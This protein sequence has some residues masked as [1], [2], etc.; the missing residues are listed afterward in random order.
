MMVFL[1]LFQVS[2]TLLPVLHVGALT[3]SGSMYVNCS[4]YSATNTIDDT[5]DFLPGV[6]EE[7]SSWPIVTE[8]GATVQANWRSDQYEYLNGTDVCSGQKH[9]LYRAGQ[10]DLTISATEDIGFFKDWVMCHA[11]NYLN[12]NCRSDEGFNYHLFNDTVITCLAGELC[13]PATINSLPFDFDCGD[14]GL[15]A[16]E[17]SE[18]D[19]LTHNFTYSYDITGP[20]LTPT[21]TQ[22]AGTT[23]KPVEATTLPWTNT[24][25]VSFECFDNPQEPR[26]AGEA[27]W[28]SCP[29]RDF[30]ANITWWDNSSP[31][32]STQEYYNWVMAGYVDMTPLSQFVV[33]QGTDFEDYMST[34]MGNFQVMD[35]GEYDPWLSLLFKLNLLTNA[36]L[37]APFQIQRTNDNADAWDAWWNALHDLP[38]SGELKAFC[39]S[40]AQDPSFT[41]WT[42]GFPGWQYC[43][44]DPVYGQW[45]GP[46]IN[47]LMEQ[48]GEI[49]VTNLWTLST[50]RQTAEGSV[51]PNV[52]ANTSTRCVPET[53]GYSKTV[54][55]STTTSTQQQYSSSLTLSS[56]IQVSEKADVSIGV[57]SGEEQTTIKAGVS[58][59]ASASI[60]SGTSATTTTSTTVNYDATPSVPPGC[61]LNTTVFV[62]QTTAEMDIT[63]DVSYGN[64]TVLQAWVNGDG[65]PVMLPEYTGV[66]Q[67]SELV[68]NGK[69]T[70][71]DAVRNV[72]KLAMNVI[73]AQW[74]EMFLDSL[75]TSSMTGTSNVTFAS[76]R[77]VDVWS[78]DTASLIAANLSPDVCDE[79]LQEEFPCQVS[80]CPGEHDIVTENRRS[81]QAPNNSLESDPNDPS[82]SEALLLSLLNY[83]D[84]YTPEK[85]DG[86]KNRW[87]MHDNC[88]TSN[89][90]HSRD[91]GI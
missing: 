14:Y 90:D 54:T 75:I 31:D 64:N 78:C 23:R 79:L 84:C 80:I 56:E 26:F 63:A 72:A 39:D 4:A 89:Y 61:T 59:T 36:I 8:N 60:T 27:S 82:D 30:P 17:P 49:I 76:T 1:N 67:L 22:S 70:T 74:T 91:L 19:D 35:G 7:L 66:S 87:Y 42:V 45:T 24:G 85:V 33:E 15:V 47:A 68:Q 43:S 73:G 86:Y 57:L 34:R 10:L 37:G 16:T 5:W 41:P 62:T 6:F 65:I 9:C 44:Q 50:Q 3:A 55:Q 48:S 88:T 13:L 83:D 29:L 58:T 52:L 46:S 69:L 2:I 77:T 53:V 81:L 40:N 12:F 11:Y 20:T 28:G 38:P 18:E 25:A 21:F 71:T 32:Q 51:V